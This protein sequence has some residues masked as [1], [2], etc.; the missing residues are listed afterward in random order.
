MSRNLADEDGLV[1]VG[2]YERAMLLHGVS[3]LG[4]VVKV[5]SSTVHGDVEAPLYPI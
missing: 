3:P 4:T 1:M 5:S 2:H